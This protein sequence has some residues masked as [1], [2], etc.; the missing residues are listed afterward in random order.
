MTSLA[1]SLAM[2][3]MNSGLGAAITTAITLTRAVFTWG[4]SSAHGDQDLTGVSILQDAALQIDAAAVTATETDFDG[5]TVGKYTV[6]NGKILHN[7]GISGNTVTPYGASGLVRIDTRCSHDVPIGATDLAVLHIGDNNVIAGD[8]AAVTNLVAAM[9][10]M[11]T[12]VDVS[13]RPYLQCVNTRGGI[14]VATYS[15][16]PMGYYPA[17]KDALFR[18]FEAVARGKVWDFY[19]TLMDHANDFGLQDLTNDQA[20]IDKGC[21][22][23][24]FMISDGSHNNQFGYKVNSR[25]VLVPVVDAIEGGTPFAVR[26]N[27]VAQSPSSPAGGDVIGSVNMFGSGG[28][29]ALDASNTQTDYAISSTGQITRVG[30]TLP[31]RDLTQVKV[32]LS[33]TGRNARVQPNIWVGEKA[34][35]GDS[36]LVEFDGYSGLNT[37]ASP[38]SNAARLL[39][40]FRLQGGTGQDGVLNN[41]LGG[42]SQMLLRRLSGNSLDVVW[43]TSKS[44]NAV[45]GSWTS[46]N[47]LFRVG[48][49][50]RWVA[51]A[52]DVPNGTAI[53]NHWTAST[54][55]T[56]VANSAGAQTTLTGDATQLVRLDQPIGF[57][58]TAYSLSAGQIGTQI[59]CFRIG[60]LWMGSPAT[61]P[62]MSTQLNRELFS[63][64]AGT[65]PNS[66]LVN[67]VDGVTGGMTPFLYAR[68][69][70]ADWRRANFIGGSADNWGFTNWKN[71]STGERGYLKTI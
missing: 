31:A 45:I 9:A 14:N 5:N 48:D 26:Q 59:G 65:A 39:V 1:L 69:N 22:P 32:Q 49:T 18:K 57:G 6:S 51:L 37:F 27:I 43:R 53:M 60:D 61:I 38:W 3:P 28:T 68:G 4:A 70:A 44:G 34:K 55:G 71:A 46:A 11:R 63:T 47:N 42:T 12:S 13:S 40:V 41:I 19:L 66:T 62:D 33:K 50:P 36:H 56:T 2:R 21:S 23:R 52:I 17:Y 15:E 20:D 7:R 35:A 10:S 30:S 54:T 16:P 25:Y 8:A 64:S 29:C 67:S 24:G 58:N